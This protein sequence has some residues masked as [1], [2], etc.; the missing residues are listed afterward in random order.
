MSTS[1]RLTILAIVVVIYSTPAWSLG[2]GDARVQS[3]IGQPLELHI[4][5]LTS[6]GDDMDSVSA[7]LASADDFALI[8]ASREAISV[9]L[10]FHVREGN[11]SSGAFILVTS[12][13]AVSNP[14]LRLVV[15]V[16]WSSG[17]LLREYTVFLDPP[18]V[19]SQ[20]PAPVVT[21][22][23]QEQATRSQSAAPQAPDSAP[24]PEPIA[25]PAAVAAETAPPPAQAETT[26][27]ISATANNEEQ[28]TAVSEEDPVEESTPA[29]SLQTSPNRYGPVQNG[30]TLWQI[31]SNH[32]GNS[33]LDMNQVMV[34]I[35]RKNPDA[36]LRDNINLLKRGATLDLPSEAEMAELSSAEANALVAQQE[37][38]FRMRS[39]LASSS[40]PLLASESVS[41]SPAGIP[42]INE[43]SAGNSDDSEPA[44]ADEA[45][46]RLEIVPASDED[47]ASGEPGTGAVPGGD[48]S[49]E[50]AANVRE[51]LARTEEAL[52]SAQQENVY[53]Q[54]RIAELEAQ[55]GDPEGAPSD[56]LIADEELADLEERLQEE[57]LSEEEAAPPV[58]EE[59]ASSIPRVRTLD[60]SESDRPWYSGPMIW[61]IMIIIFL[62]AVIGWIF[63]RRRAVEHY[64]LDAN[65]V[66]AP[67]SGLKDEAEDILRALDAD[68][69]DDGESLTATDD[70]ESAES[71]VKITDASEA[72]EEADATDDKPDATS[73]PA[74]EKPKKPRYLYKP[75]HEDATVLDENSSDPEI[76]LD[77]ARAYISMGDKEA[78]RAILDEVLNLGNDDQKAEAREM[79][80]K[81]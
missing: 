78:A 51:E 2:L 70:A 63:N 25:E 26:P 23:D 17:R 50:V 38:A 4:D 77:L 69:E 61:I 33:G 29:Q 58:V 79:M 16:N 80:D 55:L 6:P 62:A 36:F 14:V 41:N 60:E 10:S 54:E 7:R 13:L 65:R 9:P 53:L 57:R 27:A 47:L 76:Q 48:G 22:P 3:F 64:D 21:Q 28:V 73:E 1:I 31:A 44:P 5:L 68:R 46:A 20:A 24:D 71:F 81:I 67:V 8:G 66:V 72:G 18:T 52:I 45:I 35:Q 12:R 75:N 74:P 32:K 56:G 19:P 59:A 15:E 39:S 49:D 30:Q 43:T 42:D 37:A 40:T 34:A 11:A